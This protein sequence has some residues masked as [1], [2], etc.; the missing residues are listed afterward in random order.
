[1]RSLKRR[2]DGKGER[3]YRPFKRIVIDL[4]DLELL[5][6]DHPAGKCPDPILRKR[7]NL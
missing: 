4:E 2:N 7:K 3:A 1:L 6:V 5:R